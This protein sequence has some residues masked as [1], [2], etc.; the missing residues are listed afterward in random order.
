MRVEDILQAAGGISESVVEIDDNQEEE[1]EEE[2]PEGSDLAQQVHF[3]YVLLN[4]HIAFLES[5]GSN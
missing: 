2:N 3:N 1:S 5:R 4:F